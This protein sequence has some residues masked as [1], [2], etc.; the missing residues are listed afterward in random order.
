MSERRCSN[1]K[2][3]QAE[4]RNRPAVPAPDWCEPTCRGCLEACSAVLRAA[5]ALVVDRAAGIEREESAA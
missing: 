3:N 4:P 2:P 5:V 1:V